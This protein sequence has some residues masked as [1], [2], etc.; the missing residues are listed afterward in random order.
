LELPPPGQSYEDAFGTIYAAATKFLRPTAI[1]SIDGTVA[2]EKRHGLRFRL[3][4]L[5]AFVEDL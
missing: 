1:E 3:M 2:I 5:E 4:D